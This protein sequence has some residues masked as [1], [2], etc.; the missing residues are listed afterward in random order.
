[1]GRQMAFWKYDDGV[2]L[3]AHDVYEKACLNEETV[4]GLSMLPVGD[5]LKK[6]REVFSDYDMLD[7]YNFES[8]KGSFTI[9]T[10][11]QM[12]M[13]DCSWSMLTEELNKLI[14]IMLAFGCPFYDPQIDT[15]FDGK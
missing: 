15:R 8:G 9:Y 2:E 7:E 3:N 13:F 5:I 11:E 12:V 4:I 6:V 14:D 10:S 1:M